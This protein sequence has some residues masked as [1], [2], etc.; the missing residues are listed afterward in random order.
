MNYFEQESER[1]RFRKI[2]VK[3]IPGWTEFF[4][5]NDHL[6]F[7]G[8][9][10][11][12]SEEELAKEWVM[13]QLGR[14]ETQGLGHL[15]VETKAG[16]VFIGMGGIIPRELEGRIEHEIAYS[17]K[18]QF[19][20][21]GYGTELAQTMKKFGFEHIPTDRFVSII[22]IRNKRSI[23]VAK[24]NGMKALFRTTYL[25]MTVDVYGIKNSNSSTKV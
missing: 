23:Q 13:T 15:A 10:L 25:G 19:W 20:G 14:Y 24:K 8:I 11:N 7:L 2:T 21:K 1:L 3:D 9:D 17:L 12:K 16:G 18:P 22:D 6:S 5:N 4:Y